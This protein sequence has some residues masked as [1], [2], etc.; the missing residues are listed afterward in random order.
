MSCD[1]ALSGGT[2]GICQRLVVPKQLRVP[3]ITRLPR[4]FRPRLTGALMRRNFSFECLAR[5]LCK[6]CCHLF[7]TLVVRLFQFSSPLLCLL[8]CFGQLLVCLPRRLSVFG[9]RFSDRFRDAPIRFSSQ[10]SQL[11]AVLFLLSE[12]FLVSV[13]GCLKDASLGFKLGLG[14]L[15]LGLLLLLLSLL[16]GKR[17]LVPCRAQPGVKVRLC[18]TQLVQML[19]LELS[20]RGCCSGLL[21]LDSFVCCSLG[22]HGPGVLFLGAL[23]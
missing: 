3:L 1:G 6:L 9:F 8:Q 23:G 20:Q 22:S 16:D 4:G 5:R 14:N 7:E 15:S 18:A 2:S 17:K 21:L 13:F 12:Y 11:S 10:R 19:V